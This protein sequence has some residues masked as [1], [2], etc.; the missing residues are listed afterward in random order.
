MPATL[1]VVSTPIG[2]LE[3][4]TLRALDVRRDALVLPNLKNPSR[5][6]KTAFLSA[7]DQDLPGELLLFQHGAP[8]MSA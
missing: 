1:F 8:V 6:V 4:I 2:N 7:G 5:P 3:D